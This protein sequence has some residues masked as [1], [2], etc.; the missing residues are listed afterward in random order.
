[1]FMQKGDPN[2]VPPEALWYHTGGM[3]GGISGGPS[4]GPP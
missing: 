2:E 4:I 1:M 3:F